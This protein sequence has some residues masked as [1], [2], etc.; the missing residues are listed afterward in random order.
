MKSVLRYTAAGVALATFGFASAAQAATETASAEA[1]ILAALTV[2]LDLNDNTL[3]FGSIAESGSGGTV[4]LTSG[5]S[6]TCS[7]GLLCTGTPMVPS[8]LIEGTPDADVSISFTSNTIPLTGPG[9]P[10]DVDLTSSIDNTNLSAGGSASFTV[11]GVLDVA[12]G[13]A[14]GSYTGQLEVVVIYN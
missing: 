11:G 3:D 14:P 5:G 13:Q 12:A 4:T 6:L 1:E 7:T 8:F 2:T 10:M 9:A